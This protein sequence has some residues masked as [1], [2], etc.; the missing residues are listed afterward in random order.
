MKLANK[1]VVV[2]EAKAK[3]RQRHLVGIEKFQ[4]W[5][6]RQE[7]TTPEQRVEMFD[8]FIDKNRGK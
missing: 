7:S 2:P 8:F 1:K 4:A 6:E 3:V 5:L